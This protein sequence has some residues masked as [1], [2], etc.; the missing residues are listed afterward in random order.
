MLISTG[1]KAKGELQSAVLQF[2]NYDYTWSH[3]GDTLD[4]RYAHAV[5]IVD[6]QYFDEVC[7]YNDEGYAKQLKSHNVFW[8][9]QHCIVFIN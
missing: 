1:G 8:Y 6:F 5:S 4:P 9:I 3:V 7:R 2:D